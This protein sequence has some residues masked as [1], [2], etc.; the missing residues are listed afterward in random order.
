MSP[1][2]QIMAGRWS[3]RSRATRSSAA[4]FTRKRARITAFPSC[5]AF[6]NGVHEPAL[7]PVRVERSQDMGR[8]TN[9]RLRSN[10]TDVEMSLIVFP[11]I[12]LKGGQVV[13][14]AEGDMNRATVYGDN[15]AAQAILFAEAGAQHMHVVDL[16]RKSVGSGKSGSVSVNPG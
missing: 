4:S 8:A 16:D 2:S 11:A 6:W 15:P 7:P 13:R 12:D 10:R 1:P 9:S 14:L 5:P 3:P